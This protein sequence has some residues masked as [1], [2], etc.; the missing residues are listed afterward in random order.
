MDTIKVIE[1]MAIKEAAKL[2]QTIE[3]V[4]FVKEH[5]VKILRIIANSENGLDIDEAT[6]L[7]TVISEKLDEL[8]LIKEEYYLE[9]SSPG[10]ERELKNNSDIEKQ[11]GSYIYIS[12]YEKIDNVKEYYGDLI[13]FVDNIITMRINVKGRIKEISVP[14]E[15]VSKIRMAVKF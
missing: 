8:D 13:S 3:E 5:G 6:A 12:L 1:E 7:N 15:K 2:N 10:L 9:V 4:S 14:K 11:I